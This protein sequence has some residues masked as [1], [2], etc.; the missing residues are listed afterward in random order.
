M[1][2]GRRLRTKSLWSGS[3]P[4]VLVTLWVGLGPMPCWAQAKPPPSAPDTTVPV[5]TGKADVSDVPVLL[6]GLGTVEGFKVVEIKAQVNGILTSL[7]VL[8]GTEVKQGDI[9]AEIDPRPYKAAFDQ[10][11]AQKAEDVAMLKSSQLDL[12]RYANLAQKNF[13]A[14]QQVDDQQGTVSKLQASIAADD[15][16]IET[17]KINLDY[18]VI[19][20][21]FAGRVS[22]YQVDVGN[23]IQT[24]SQ[25]GI[26]SITQDKPIAV[27][28]TLPESD[29]VQVQAA[30][31]KGDVPV[32]VD[33]GSTGKEL[34]TGKLLT[35]NNT[36][37]TTTGTIS[38]K[39]EFTN[40][41]DHLWPGQF[42]NARVQVNILPKAVTV[43]IAAIEHGPS[44]LFIYTVKPDQSV[45]PVNVKVGY[46]NNSKAVVTQ[47]LSGGETVVVSG[48]SRLAPGVK[49]RALE[50][51]AS[52]TQG[53]APAAD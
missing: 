2:A 29:L 38:L 17:A 14:I 46:Q 1:I 20:A 44:G 41:D 35:P 19:R 39:A 40:E 43:P 6:E 4:R 15:A 47:G 27:V 8:E 53:D 10:A 9:V 3:T 12:Q 52:Q 7:P 48:Q 33:D 42:V 34:A 21:P 11:T 5:G 36:I 25:T 13:A 32:R 26:I 28:F 23:L 45:A 31:R 51:Q 16:A 49:V 37:D 22:L 24:A 30:R 18:C 50:A